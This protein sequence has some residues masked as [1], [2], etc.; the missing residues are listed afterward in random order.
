MLCRLYVVENPGKQLFRQETGCQESQFYGKSRND[1]QLSGENAENGFPGHFFRGQSLYPEL[2]TGPVIEVG[3]Y[4][5]GAEQAD[6]NAALVMAQFFR[7]GQ[8]ETNHIVF[9]CVVGREQGTGKKT[10]AGCNI[11]DAPGHS[12]KAVPVPPASLFP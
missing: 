12:K 8:C 9:R 1:Q 7:N 2:Y 10:G 4:R 11:E 6:N 5:A 3:V